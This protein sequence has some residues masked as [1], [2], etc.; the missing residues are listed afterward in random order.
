LRDKVIPAGTYEGTDV[1]VDTVYNG[2]ELVVNKNVDDDVVY[3]L[4]KTLKEASSLKDIH[5]IVEN[6][7]E[8][9]AA[10]TAIE[11]HPGATQYFEDAGI[12]K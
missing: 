8:K 6:F 5:S 11:L 2:V 9:I 1:D 7:D 4:V 10:E 12:L 3:N